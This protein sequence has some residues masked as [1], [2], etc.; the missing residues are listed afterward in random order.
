M[1]PT[2]P[3]DYHARLAE[4]F[5]LDIKAGASVAELRRVV[6]QPSTIA[7]LNAAVAR[8]ATESE[9][10]AAP[11]IGVH[12]GARRTTDVPDATR[13]ATERG[14]RGEPDHSTRSKR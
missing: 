6:F 5:Y 4:A 9:A 10:A 8:I 7:A 2:T 3:P 12:S 1:I 13:P 11:I 14:T